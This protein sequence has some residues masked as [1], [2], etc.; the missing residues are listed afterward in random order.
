MLAPEAQSQSTVVN[1]WS[2]TLHIGLNFS[3]SGWLVIGSP[4]TTDSGFEMALE[5]VPAQR[6]ICESGGFCRTLS[7]DQLSCCKPERD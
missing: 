3:G 1:M 4:I 7:E 5:M 2:I 6:L